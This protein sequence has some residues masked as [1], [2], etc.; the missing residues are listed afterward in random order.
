MINLSGEEEKNKIAA[1]LRWGPLISFI[2]ASQAWQFYNGTGIIKR[3][4]CRQI[5]N[6]AVLLVGYDYEGHTPYYI[7]KN[8]WGPEY[9]DGGYVKL[10]AGTN[11]C[12]V[13]SNLVVACTSNCEKLKKLKNLVQRPHS[14]GCIEL[15][16]NLAANSSS[17]GLLFE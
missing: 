9:G 2:D 4:H 12:N 6:H 1:L 14:T 5:S 10:E 8:S 16:A 7:I 17:T 15:T 11:A 3:R 13:A